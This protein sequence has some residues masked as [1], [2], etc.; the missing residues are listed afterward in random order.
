MF[1]ELL[2]NGVYIAPSPYEAAMMSTEHTLEDIEF[3]IN[4]FA[5]AFSKM[6][7]QG[8]MNVS[9]IEANREPATT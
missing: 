2:K 7:Q 6:S 9:E 1:N 5:K 3:T 8:V 4:A